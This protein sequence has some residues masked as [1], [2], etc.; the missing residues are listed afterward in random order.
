MGLMAQEEL[1]L[2]IDRF[3]LMGGRIDDYYLQ[4]FKYCKRALVN[5]NG[6]FGGNS[7]REAIN[8]AIAGQKEKSVKSAASL[9][10]SF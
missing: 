2:L 3:R 10:N 9:K 7:L 5:L 6:W 4:E 8:K 1:S